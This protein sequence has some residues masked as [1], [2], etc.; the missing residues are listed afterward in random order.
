[1][2]VT[3]CPCAR[4]ASRTRNGKRPLPAMRP[5]FMPQSRTASTSCLSRQSTVMEWTSRRADYSGY[6]PHEPSV[7]R[8]Q[9]LGA[10]SAHRTTQ[11]DAALRRADEIDEIPDFRRGQGRV[12]LDLGQGAGG[13]QLGEQQIAV[14][15]FQLFDRVGSE[16]AARQTDG[17]DAEDP[18]GA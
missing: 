14:S 13:V 9:F 16:I 5:S 4:A 1:M 8:H 10:V 11:D 2:I 3:S 12:V 17:I 7:V 15:A 18:R 6:Q